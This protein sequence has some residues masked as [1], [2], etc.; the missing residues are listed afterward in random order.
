[1]VTILEKILSEEKI[2]IESILVARLIKKT[3]SNMFVISLMTFCS[4][5]YLHLHKCFI[6]L[7]FAVYSKQSKQNRMFPMCGLF[8]VVFFF[9]FL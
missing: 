9:G 2:V 7:Y 3:D 6:S 4:L 1:M 5:I 8:C